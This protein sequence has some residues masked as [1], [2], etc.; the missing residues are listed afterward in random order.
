MMDTINS[1]KNELVVLENE[2]QK[3]IDAFNYFLEVRDS[4]TSSPL[5]TEDCFTYYGNA[6]SNLSNVSKSMDTTTYVTLVDLRDTVDDVMS[7]V[8]IWLLAC[9]GKINQENYD[10]AVAVINELLEKALV[11]RNIF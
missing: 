3:Y 9:E 1:D 8:D 5:S 4:D 7:I 2:Y 10:R 11:S 6:R